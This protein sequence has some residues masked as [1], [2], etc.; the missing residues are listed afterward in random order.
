MNKYQSATGRAISGRWL[1][2]W[3]AGLLAAVLLAGFCLG[4]DK[5]ANDDLVRDRVMLK[6][7]SDP[8]AKVGGLDVESKDGVVTLTGTVETEAQKDKAGKLAKKVKG[9]KQVINNINLRDRSAA[10]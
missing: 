3:L 10:R 6:V 9:V 2:R 7:G 8:D 4:A 1:M 5:K